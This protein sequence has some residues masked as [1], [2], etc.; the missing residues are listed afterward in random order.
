MARERQR[1]CGAKSGVN[2]QGVR[3]LECLGRLFHHRNNAADDA[4]VDDEQKL[5][6][7]ILLVLCCL[8]PS[9]NPEAWGG[10]LCRCAFECA[11]RAPRTT[12]EWKGCKL[13]DSRD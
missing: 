13:I 11:E 12:R 8:S 5:R 7:S 4:R 1:V 3:E 10:K 9:T 2:E 6:L